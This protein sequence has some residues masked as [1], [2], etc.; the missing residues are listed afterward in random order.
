[1]NTALNSWDFQSRENFFA[2]GQ[3]TFVEWMCR[4]PDSGKPA[5]ISDVL[6]HYAAATAATAQLQTNALTGPHTFHFYQ[7][8]VTLSPV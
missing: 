3:V 2:F 1:M 7:M 6:D 8:D 5:F 4:L